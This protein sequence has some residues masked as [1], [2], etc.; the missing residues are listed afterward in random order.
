MNHI[1]ERL[2]D[3]KSHINALIGQTTQELMS[4]G[5]PALDGKSNKVCISYLLFYIYIININI[6]S[7]LYNNNYHH[8]DYIL[9]SLSVKTSY[10]VC[11]RFCSFYRRHNES[12]LN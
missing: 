3:I 10:K 1:R 11:K 5:E 9:G 6:N 12:Y 8:N 7:Q 2:P 4:Y